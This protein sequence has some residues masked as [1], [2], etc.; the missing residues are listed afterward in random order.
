MN[1]GALCAGAMSADEARTRIAAYLPLLRPARGALSKE[2]LDRAGRAFKWFPT[3]GEV[4]AFLDQEADDLRAQLTRAKRIVAGE[5]PNLEASYTEAYVA[6]AKAGRD[7]A[8]KP[9]LED[10][11][12][13]VARPP[14]A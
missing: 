1:L 8:T 14:A 9:R 3:Y 4:A 11:G 12:L 6:W 13:A 10:Y 2:S 7:P 5:R